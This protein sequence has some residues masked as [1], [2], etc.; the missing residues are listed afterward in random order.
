MPSLY[1][2]FLT[3]A[4]EH[5]GSIA[6]IE[7]QL[8]SPAS[9]QTLIRTPDNRYLAE[10]AACIFRAGFV[11]RV[12]EQKWS[13]FETVFNHFIPVWVASRSPEELENL[14]RDPRIIRNLS[15]VRAVQENAM[16][17]LD[18]IKQHGS[19]GQFLADWPDDDTIGLW[20]YLK[21]H[22]SR[23]GGNSGAYFLRFVGK[24]TF[25]LSRDVCIALRT[26]GVIDT[27]TPTSKRDLAKIQACFNNLRQDSG[28]SHAELSRILAMSRGPG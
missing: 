12:V 23:L 13:G 17:V 8:P 19:V 27:D 25:I 26:E 11:W 7:E 18:L 1:K 4:I 3:Q 2:S 10:M 16:M 24:D 20:A 28:R 22:G 9:P 15:K 6:A 5:H 14:A 21:K